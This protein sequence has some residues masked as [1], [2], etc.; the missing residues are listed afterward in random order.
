MSKLTLYPAID[1]KDG[2]CVRLVH[3]RMESAMVYNKDPAGQA[4][5]FKEAGF[6]W[7]HIVDLDGAFSGRSE[8][9]DAVAAI[10]AAAGMKTQ[11]GGGIRAMADIETWLERGVTRVILGTAA[12]RDPDFVRRFS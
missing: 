10:L 11:L 4:V 7:L 9:T 5:A 12:V 3:G 6:D 2:H 1:L 8:N